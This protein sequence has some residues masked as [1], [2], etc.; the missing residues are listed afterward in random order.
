M[1]V[2]RKSIVS[3]TWSVVVVVVGPDIVVVVVVELVFLEEIDE[4]GFG[5]LHLL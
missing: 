3:C 5:I 4:R 1:E 2:I